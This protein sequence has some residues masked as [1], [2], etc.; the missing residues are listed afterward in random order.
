MRLTGDSLTGVAFFILESPLTN[1]ADNIFISGVFI[2]QKLIFISN[3]LNNVVA[4]YTFLTVFILP[5]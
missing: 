3:I 1:T 2:W 4:A 5:D